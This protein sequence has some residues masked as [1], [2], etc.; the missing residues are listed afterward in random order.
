MQK[1]KNFV[2]L[3]QTIEIREF[4]RTYLNVEYDGEEKRITHYEMNKYLMEKGYKLPVKV[5]FSK[6]NKQKLSD[7]SYVLVREETKKKK[8]GKIIPYENPLLLSFGKLLN[9]LQRERDYDKLRAIR[10]SILAENN[11]EEDWLGNIVERY[12]EEDI[13]EVNVRINRQKHY[14]QTG[15]NRYRKKG[16]Y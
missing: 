3:K 8:K 1:N 14:I 10:E 15:R 11:L 13:V 12:P 16:G 4:M 7:G 9:E 6:I 2:S 5:S